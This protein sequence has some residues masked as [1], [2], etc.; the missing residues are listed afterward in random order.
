MVSVL[1]DRVEDD[2][3]FL[4]DDKTILKIIGSIATGYSQRFTEPVNDQ[5]YI[6][7]TTVKCHLAKDDVGLIFQFNLYGTGVLSDEELMLFK[8]DNDDKKIY[9]YD[10]DGTLV[11][12]CKYEIIIKNNDAFWFHKK[13]S[14][15]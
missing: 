10:Q 1:W 6:V 14:K 3:A 11:D 12:S 13:Q 8:I 4:S 2:D 5:T 15:H 9:L 7:Q